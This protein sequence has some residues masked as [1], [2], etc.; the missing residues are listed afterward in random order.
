MSRNDLPIPPP[1]FGPP[2]QRNAAPE[3]GPLTGFVRV[4]NTEELM[5]GDPVGLGRDA[6]DR[7][8]TLLPGA[9]SD[10]VC[11]RADSPSTASG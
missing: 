4:V 10:A 3:T 6:L 2:G 5:S 8:A 1:E 11:P 9:S 7:L